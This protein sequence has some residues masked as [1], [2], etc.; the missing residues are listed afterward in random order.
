MKQPKQGYAI[1]KEAA[2]TMDPYQNYANSVVDKDQ[3]WD[4][5]LTEAGRAVIGA[6]M[7]VPI[8][9]QLDYVGTSRK[10]FEI[11]VLSQG[12]IAR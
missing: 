4:S 6:Q 2:Q 1:Q 3:I 12:Q 8:R 10:F 7:A 5:L 11:D 9:T